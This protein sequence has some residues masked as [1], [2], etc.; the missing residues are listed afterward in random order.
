LYKR[1]VQMQE[2][3]TMYPEA[4]PTGI[5]EA[6]LLVYKNEKIKG[7]RAQNGLLFLQNIQFNQPLSLFKEI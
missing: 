1:Q 3:L 7:E 4:T 6:L 2:M 5:A